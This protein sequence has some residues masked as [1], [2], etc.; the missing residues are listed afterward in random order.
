MC[1][2]R[3]S[4]VRTLDISLPG[5]S[6]TNLPEAATAPAHRNTKNGRMALVKLALTGW[7]PFL[8]SCS[9]L[10]LVQETPIPSVD[11]NTVIDPT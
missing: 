3:A 5:R 8:A 7:T 11:E 6:A 10:P 9:E 2:T 1:R 4:V